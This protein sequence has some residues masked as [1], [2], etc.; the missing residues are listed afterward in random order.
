MLHNLPVT[1]IYSLTTYV[2]GVQ[3]ASQAQE[4]QES[5]WICALISLLFFC[6]VLIVLKLSF[7]YHYNTSGAFIWLSILYA[8]LILRCMHAFFTTCFIDNMKARMW[9]FIFN[10][11]DLFMKYKHKEG[12]TWI[13]HYLHGKILSL[14]HSSTLRR[15]AVLVWL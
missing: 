11:S 3:D 12:Q 9:F 14:V 4:G 8:K 2:S 13:F 5:F 1:V 7:L 6:F 15:W 10:T